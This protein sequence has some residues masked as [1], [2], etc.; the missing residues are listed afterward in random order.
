MAKFLLRCPLN[1]YLEELT[2]YQLLHMREEANGTSNS[3]SVGELPAESL[4]DD[5]WDYFRCSED[6]ACR[7]E[8]RDDKEDS[9]MPASCPQPPQQQ[10]QQQQ[11]PQS[12]A[13]VQY[14]MRNFYC[15]F[16]KFIWYF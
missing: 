12:P 6:K 10:Q 2:C 13:A 4:V 8:P 1:G 7:F 16:K 11:Q 9:V 15:S 3:E 14:T 5:A